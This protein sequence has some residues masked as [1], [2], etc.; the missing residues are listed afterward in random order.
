MQRQIRRSLDPLGVCLAVVVLAVG[1]AAFAQ[2]KAAEDRTKPK[3]A[4]VR[5]VDDMFSEFFNTDPVEV[6]VARRT[7]KDSTAIATPPPRAAAGGPVFV[8]RWGAN[9]L[10]N[11]RIPLS[12]GVDFDGA[13][14]ERAVTRLP[15]A[16]ASPPSML[17][18]ANGRIVVV[19]VGML[20]VLDESGRTLG[21]QEYGSSVPAL[22]A[23]GKL[24]WAGN[25]KGDLSG[26]QL[27]DASIQATIELLMDRFHSR[28]FIGGR[29]DRLVVVSQEL[30]QDVHEPPVEKTMI[31]LV[32]LAY[33][34][35]PEVV[36]DRA[37]DTNVLMTAIDR[38]TIVT[39]TT[40][41]FYFLD[42]DL[43]FKDA[44]AGEFQPLGMS[45][46]EASN[47]YLQARVGLEV[48]L[49]KLNPQAKREWAVTLPSASAVALLPPV[50]GYDH[51]V[52]IV[53]QS[54]IIAFDAAGELLWQ[55]PGA[56]RIGGAFVT[57]DDYLVTT[58]GSQIAAWTIRGERHVIHDCGE[59][60]VTPPVLTEAG[61]I[62]AASANA[63]FRVDLRR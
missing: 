63:L 3:T 13:T 60:L 44:W 34:G 52:Y 33:K 40:N 11:S 36:K 35:G 7:I 19:S 48:Q 50:I 12:L 41:R 58:E 53:S 45:L 22:D 49:W 27:S 54:Q 14:D 8:N 10:L 30:D 38:E 31:E 56:G 24:L 23:E 61:Q 51:T 5:P 55:R 42:F 20:T 17:L 57:S 21:T 2:E 15:L 16:A 25:A 28:E 26:I 1:C 9:D 37:R 29:G 39:A 46:D 43:K 6:P 59:P 4:G 18:S 32:D 47:V 62:F